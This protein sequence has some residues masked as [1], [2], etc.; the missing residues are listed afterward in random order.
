[1]KNKIEKSK[2]YYIICKYSSKNNTIEYSCGLGGEQYT[3]NILYAAFLQNHKFASEH[4]AKCL[5]N[6]PMRPRYSYNGKIDKPIF[7]IA[8]IFVHRIN[9]EFK[10]TFTKPYKYV[11]LSKL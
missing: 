1:M 5:D 10:C 8:K 4:F 9:R 7:F 11:F 2:L 3:Q 6:I